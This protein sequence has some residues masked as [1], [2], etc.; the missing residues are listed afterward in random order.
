MGG[1]QQVRL[2]VV[3]PDIRELVK[4]ADVVIVPVRGDGDDRFTGQISELASHAGKPHP[5]VHDQ[6]TVPALD[7]PDVAAHQ[8]DYVRLDQQGRGIVNSRSFEPAISDRQ[9]RHGCHPTRQAPTGPGRPQDAA[10]NAALR[11]L[12][13]ST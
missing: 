3:S 7:V 6:V 1:A 13:A 10:I 8:R 5:G 11:S 9:R 12:I 2:K 4:A